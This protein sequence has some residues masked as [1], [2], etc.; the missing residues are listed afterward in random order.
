MTAK[1]VIK[2][3]DEIEEIRGK[4]ESLLKGC[5]ITVDTIKYIKSIDRTLIWTKEEVT[6]DIQKTVDKLEVDIKSAL[7]EH[8]VSE[9]TYK[10]SNKSLMVK[11]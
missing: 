7:K 10:T 6:G 2:P 1:N 9:V 4:I 5:G 8:K 11:K 3:K